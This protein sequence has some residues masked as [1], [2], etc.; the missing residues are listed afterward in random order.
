[1]GTATIQAIEHDGHVAALVA[2][3]RAA[4][5]D[6]VTGRTLALV[7][8]KCRLEVQAGGRAGPYSVQAATRHAHL[9]H[10]HQVRSRRR[11][12]R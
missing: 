4:L 1:V 9:A 6:Q 3:G 5:G 10:R 2:G 7:C 12:P 11:R 8:A